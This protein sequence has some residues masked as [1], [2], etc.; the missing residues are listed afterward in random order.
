[1]FNKDK[2]VPVSLLLPGIGRTMALCFLLVS[3]LLSDLCPLRHKAW[4]VGHFRCSPWRKR[5]HGG[6]RTLSFRSHC[7]F[8]WS[9]P[10]CGALQNIQKC[11]LLHKACAAHD[12]HQKNRS[13]H[14]SRGKYITA[15]VSTQ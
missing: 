13:H 11:F 5:L 8:S 15:Q 3:M 1:M 4:D 10:M 7:V 12:R 9:K 6:H 2:K 14:D